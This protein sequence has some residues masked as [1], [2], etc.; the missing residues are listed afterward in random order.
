MKIKTQKDIDLLAAK[1]KNDFDIDVNKYRNDEMTSKFAELLLFPKYVI[2]WGVRPVIC[3]FLIFALG[4]AIVN[5]DSIF[6]LLTYFIIGF[7]LTMIC[8]ILFA[9]VF[10]MRKM[11]SDMGSIM[12]YTIEICKDAIG[13]ISDFNKNLKENGSKESIKLL[14][15]GILH[16]VTIP[17][18]TKAVR[19]QS[20][21]I[22]Y[23]VSWII[24]KIM[25]SF[26]NLVTVQELEKSVKVSYATRNQTFENQVLEDTTN[27]KNILE[28]IVDKTVRVIEFPFK[29]LFV[30]FFLSW[31][32]LIWMVH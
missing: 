12:Q 23:P 4:Y 26:G 24:K 18:V 9:V 25:T 29:L 8:G 22:G 20:S 11:K 28:N 13:D 14:Y 17:S 5:L 3:A 1:I 27:D 30:I 15:L 16:I 10:L 21:I 32:C 7:P 6:E 31:M 2:N 19:N